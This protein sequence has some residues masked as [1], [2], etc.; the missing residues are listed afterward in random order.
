MDEKHEKDPMFYKMHQTMSEYAKYHVHLHTGSAFVKI[1][2]QR[3]KTEV[4]G[5]FVRQ[6]FSMLASELMQEIAPMILLKSE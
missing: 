2:Q 5:V 1:T 4:I 6:L 3:Y